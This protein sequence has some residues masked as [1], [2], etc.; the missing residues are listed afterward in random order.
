MYT[1]RVLTIIEKCLCLQEESHSFIIK[2]EA[3]PHIMYLTG[4]DDLLPDIESLAVVPVE[5]LEE[6]ECVAMDTDM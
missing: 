4:G 6:G 5:E 3:K 1:L 2:G